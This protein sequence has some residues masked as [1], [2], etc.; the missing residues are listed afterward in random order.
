MKVMRL[1]GFAGLIGL[2][3]VVGPVS[4]QTCATTVVIDA[5]GKIHDPARLT[6]KVDEE[7]KWE[8]DNQF[9]H[10]LKVSFTKFK[11]KSTGT[12]HHPLKIAAPSVSP[13]KGTKKKSSG[14]HVKSKTA[15]TKLPVLYKY[16]IEARDVEDKRDLEPLDPELEVTPP[17]VVVKGQGRGRGRGRLR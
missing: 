16:T 3:V 15:F 10:D 17:T 12:A 8:V 7:V 13:P 1:A 2:G 4:A 14:I 9:K 11:V 5:A 6:C